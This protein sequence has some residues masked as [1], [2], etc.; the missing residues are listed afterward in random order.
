M[1]YMILRMKNERFLRIVFFILTISV[2]MNFFLYINYNYLEEVSYKD[3]SLTDNEV[4]ACE[5]GV[6]DIEDIM[7]EYRNELIYL[8]TENY[9][10]LTR[11]ER[12]KYLK[13]LLE[14]SL[15]AL[16]CGQDITLISEAMDDNI[17]GYFDGNNML[18][19]LNDDRLMQDNPADCI[20]AVLHES[21]HAYQYACVRYMKDNNLSDNLFYYEVRQ[22]DYEFVYYKDIDRGSTVEEYKKYR[23]QWCESSAFHYELQWRD[24]V[25]EYIEKT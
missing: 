25:I 14:C 24:F 6:S 23:S 12:L 7:D 13:I 22:W 10:N 16:G 4:Y 15:N 19:A 11:E 18:I 2:A 17:N 21:Y 3:A 8:K 1:D 20:C 9:K 5:Y